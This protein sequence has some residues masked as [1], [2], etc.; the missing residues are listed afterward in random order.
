MK[1][2]NSYQKLLNDKKQKLTK[3]WRSERIR[4]LL[5]FSYYK[6]ERHASQW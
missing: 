5:Y 1:T 3:L 2:Y 4:Y 6:M